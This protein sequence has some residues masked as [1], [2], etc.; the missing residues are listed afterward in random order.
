MEQEEIWRPNRRQAEFLAIPY[1]VFEGFYGGAA[2]GG[3]S[4][5]L[6]A[7]PCVKGLINHPK[8]HGII[9]RRT[10]RQLEESLIPRAKE[11]YGSDGTTR[12]GGRYNDQKKAFTFPSGAT[13][14]FS[15][16]ETDDDAKSHQT[17]QYNYAAFDELTHFTEYQY[18][19]V[20]TRVR[21]S[22]SDLPAYIR[23]ASN[24]G[25]VGHTWV[26][27]RFVEP[28]ET[29]HV[30]LQRKLPNGKA[31]KAVFIPA[32]LTDNTALL[33]ADPDYINRLNLLPEADRRALLYG[34]WHAYSGQVFTEFRA[35]HLP[36]EPDNALHVVD[37]F[38]IPQWWPKIIAIDWGYAAMTWVGW[39]AIAPNSVSYLYR[40]YAQ[41]RK[42]ITEWASDV[43]RL[44][45]FDGNI[46]AVALD[47]SAWQH[48]GDPKQIYQQFE[49]ASGFRTEK[50]VNDR[51]GGKM[52]LHEYFRWQQRPPRYIPPEG[53]DQDLHDRIYRMYGEKRALEYKEM[54]RS[55]PPET[56]LP[57]FRVFRGA[58]PEFIGAIQA[59]MADEKDPEKVAEFPGDDPYDGGRYLIQRV[60]RYFQ[61]AQDEQESRQQLQQVLDG[62]HTTF[63]LYMAMRRFEADQGRKEIAPRR[64]YTP[65]QRRI[66]ASYRGKLPTIGD[67]GRAN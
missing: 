11:F 16:L 22:V 64:L 30:L 47:P 42:Y 56:N 29:G 51:T 27:K 35:I 46:K 8:F 44:S 53:F 2:G 28:C 59:C 25:G 7:E 54:F 19:Y 45:Q 1:S 66:A 61:E 43:A 60:H 55:Q 58:A 67:G 13:I 63:D 21:T 15:Y 37:P 5:I 38:I 52:L 33:H 31:I 36:T 14:R 24:P 23:S 39:A 10:F 34:D 57:K 20:T 9:F 65:S 40:E 32:L 48:R 6:I 49:E 18:T 17:A 41:K 4:E 3:K 50:A 26:Y 62:A 12:F